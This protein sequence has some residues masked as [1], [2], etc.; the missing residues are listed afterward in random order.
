MRAAPRGCVRAGAGAAARWTA[1]QVA[2][3]IACARARFC[4]I[5]SRA[6]ESS[7]R[8]SSDGARRAI[9]TP[10]R[11]STFFV[12][13]RAPVVVHAAWRCAKRGVS[14]IAATKDAGGRATS[15]LAPPDPPRAR[16]ARALTRPPPRG[17]RRKR[18]QRSS[19]ITGKYGA[20]R[21]VA[22]QAGEEDRGPAARLALHAASSA[23]KDSVKRTAVGIWKCKA[24][25]VLHA[26]GAY[27]M[28]TAQ[29]AQVRSTI[30]RLREG[31]DL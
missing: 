14:A 24:C 1:D 27:S 21:L 23:R 13:I 18:G 2:G 9:S 19:G 3:K 5:A 15:L 10:G 29:A 12:S 26:G 7:P 16:E 20:V 25:S 17:A 28:N 6:P 8:G 22:P 30:R 11:P 31:T 4:E